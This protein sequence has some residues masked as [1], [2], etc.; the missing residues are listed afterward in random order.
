MCAPFQMFTGQI[1]DAF[2]IDAQSGPDAL[3]W[4]KR[5]VLNALRETFGMEVAF[6]SRFDAGDRVFDE[7]ESSFDFDPPGVARGAR[8][9]AQ[10]SY[11]LRVLE[12][13]VPA[14]IHDAR[15]VASV[16][17]IAATRDWPI[18]AHVS[19]PIRLSNGR[20]FGMLCAFG[21][22]PDLTLSLRDQAMFELCAA[23]L[24]RDIETS[25]QSEDADRDP[26]LQAAIAAGDF[27]FALQPVFD[28]VRGAPIGYELF[29]RFA[30]EFGP[31]EEVFR[32]AKYLDLILPLE[33]V[34]LQRAPEVLALIPPHAF[35]S[36]N[37][38]VSTFE[39][40]DPA[41]LLAQVGPGRLVLELTEHERVADYASL[42]ARVARAQASAV[43]LAI[44]DV[45]AGYASFRHV[46]QLRPDI[47]KIDRALISGIE[48]SAAQGSF[49]A[50]LADYARA[51]GTQVIAEGIERIEERDW[52]LAHGITWGQGYLLGRPQMVRPGLVLA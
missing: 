19:V 7:V 38:S 20:C 30:P 36:L 22:K 49:V 12:G 46:M 44:D 31:T 21:R 18:G 52:L 47:V 1:K 43:R 15:M 16:Q 32:R 14:L 4:K 8:G 48:V 28:M 51:T 40:F 11:C 6:I 29:T 9:P 24:A 10:G 33:E 45:G 26:P 3:R 13:E 42:A 39:D 37:L 23:L 41:P 25:A 17:D 5:K 50:A 2:L 34:I 27:A 35:L